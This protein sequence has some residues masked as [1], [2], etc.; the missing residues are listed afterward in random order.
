MMGIKKEKKKWKIHL[1]LFSLYSKENNTRSDM[2]SYSRVSNF[3]LTFFECMSE[4]F[5]LKKK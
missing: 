1:I 5:W 2:G 3:S 4:N